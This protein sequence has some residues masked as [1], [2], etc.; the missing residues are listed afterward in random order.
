MRSKS[1]T[2][3]SGIADVAKVRAREDS[4]RDSVVSEEDPP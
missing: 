4:R 2:F 3:D 1:F